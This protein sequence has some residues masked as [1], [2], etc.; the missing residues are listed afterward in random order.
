M[1]SFSREPLVWRRV[2]MTRKAVTDRWD[3][4]EKLTYAVRPEYAQR[5]GPD[6][7]D[8]T[9]PQPIIYEIWD[10]SAKQVCWIA[11]E[12]KTI[13]EFGKPPLNFRQFFPCPRPAFG[14]HATGSLIPTPEPPE[15]IDGD[16]EGS[17]PVGASSMWKR[18]RQFLLRPTAK[19]SHSATAKP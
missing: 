5:Y 10:R 9:E 4:A 1:L 14:T 13:L 6:V 2:Y 19:Q 17:G 16:K 3:K 12:E 18:I 7:K 8:A 11:K 15:Q